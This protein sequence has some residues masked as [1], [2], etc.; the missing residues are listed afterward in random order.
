MNYFA[1]NEMAMIA[2]LLIQQF[3]MALLTPDPRTTYGLG[4]C[5]PE[6]VLIRY[7]RRLVLPESAS[8]E[9]AAAV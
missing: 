9:A 5:R 7:R 8:V 4:A 1:N 6:L 3:E 2:A